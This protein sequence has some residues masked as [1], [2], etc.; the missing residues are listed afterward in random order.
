MLSIYLSYAIA[1]FLLI[2]S[3][4]PVISLVIADAKHGWPIGT[5]IGSAISALLLLTAALLFI[6]F[7]LVVDEQLL[8]IGRVL[9]GAYLAYLGGRLFLSKQAIA[10]TSGH[11][12][13]CF[14]RAMKVGL[15]N[16]KDI[17]FLLAFLPSFIIPEQSLL[18][19]S[20][21]L[22]VIWAVIDMSIM[23]VYAGAAKRLLS[24]P[25]FHSLLHY[26]P[27]AFMLL[28]GTLSSY[29]GIISLLA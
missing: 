22:L 12:K 4:G 15:S 16:P 24:Y 17:L 11:H 25:F 3:P 28:L 1:V 27:S 26:L 9:G 7:A 8:D 20:L 2:S 29:L 18:E 21:I 5:L 6:H 14:W 23:L 10:I 19:Q 13:D